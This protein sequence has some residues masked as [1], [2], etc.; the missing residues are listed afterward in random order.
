M[1]SVSWDTMS[2][3]FVLRFHCSKMLGYN[4][5]KKNDIHCHKLCVRILIDSYLMGFFLVGKSFFDVS[6]Q[7]NL[8]LFYCKETLVSINKLKATHQFL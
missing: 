8:K 5:M 4:V 3:L 1:A 6:I 2:I 7:I